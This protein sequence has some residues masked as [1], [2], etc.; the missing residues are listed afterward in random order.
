MGRSISYPS[1]M[2][3]KAMEK[4]VEYYLGLPYTIELILDS[5]ERTR[6]LTSVQG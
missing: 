1:L 2:E 3:E 4:T 6:T 5:R